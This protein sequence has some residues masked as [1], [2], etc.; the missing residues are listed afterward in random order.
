ML[1]CVI[2]SMFVFLFVI[3]F[4]LFCSLISKVRN[5]WQQVQLQSQRR[6]HSAS[7]LENATWF[8]HYCTETDS[9]K[10]C[11]VYMKGTSLVDVYILY[12]RT[13][14][15]HFQILISKCRGA[16]PRMQR[17]FWMLMRQWQFT[18][19][20][21]RMTILTLFL[22]ALPRSCWTFFWLGRTLGGKVLWPLLHRPVFLNS[23]N[24]DAISS[25]PNQVKRA[26]EPK[27]NFCSKL[28]PVVEWAKNDKARRFDT[29]FA[30]NIL[31]GNELERATAELIC[32]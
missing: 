4:M 5:R 10:R 12:E 8:Q 28:V 6:A 27:T 16:M 25:L 7:L 19:V 32:R 20:C 9:D 30:A 1:F 18:E 2:Y 17:S 23:C 29:W 26:E 21:Y 3:I 24:G 15:C 31:V 11:T 14:G 22:V 13:I